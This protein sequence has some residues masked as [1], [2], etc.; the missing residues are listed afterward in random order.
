MINRMR[1]N[2]YKHLQI[3]NKRLKFKIYKEL[4]GKQIT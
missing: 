1:E 2:F 3:S 4:N